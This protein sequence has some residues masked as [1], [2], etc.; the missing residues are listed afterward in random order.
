M[1]MDSHLPPTVDDLHEAVLVL[2]GLVQGLVFLL[3][4]TDPLLEI[5]QNF[6]LRQ[7]GVVWTGS[8]N[9]FNIRLDN[10]IIVT[11]GLHKK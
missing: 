2:T 8:F 4:V 10:L 5:L 3:I 9:F 7:V 1:F 6:V 11:D